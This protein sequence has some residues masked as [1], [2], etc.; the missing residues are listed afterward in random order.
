MA[1]S[2]LRFYEQRGLIA[3]ERSGSGQRRYPPSG[4]AAIAFVVFAQRV[5]LTLDE[6]AVELGKLP[7][8]RAPTRRDWSRL[9]RTWT[10]RIDERIHELE[11]LR[12]G[13]TPVHRVRL[14]RSTAA[15]SRTPATGPPAR[16]RPALLDRRSAAA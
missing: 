5:G 3:S 11:R 10:S 7:S 14:C 1:A 4:A 2:A 9:S 15:G 13:L 12:A 8:G 6:I 16:A